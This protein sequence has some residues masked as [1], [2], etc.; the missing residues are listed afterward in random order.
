MIMLKRVYEEFSEDDGVRILVERLWPRGISKEKA[1]IDVW[2]RDIAPS[3]ELRKWF[4]HEDSKWEEFTQRYRDE[5]IA[6]N[7][8]VSLRKIISR[9][10]NV[11]LIY[12]AKNKEHNSAIVLYGILEG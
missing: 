6:N 11:T 2:M 12:S 8:L 4:N 5:L 7:E 3:T 10:R 9:N 1:R